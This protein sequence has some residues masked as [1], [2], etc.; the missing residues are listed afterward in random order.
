MN[1]KKPDISGAAS[2]PPMS[3]FLYNRMARP[4]ASP[5]KW[6]YRIE[7]T[8]AENWPERGPALIASNH[9]SNF[10]PVLL[11]LAYPGIIRWMAKAELWK[12]PG[13]G[14]LINRLGAF[15]VHRGEADR[16][17][18]REA[19][20]LLRQGGVVGMFPEGTR[21][22]DGRLGEPQPGVGMLALE[23]GI[24]VVPVRIRGSEGI[25]RG[26]IPRRPLV[27]ITV[28]KPVPMDIDGMS[29]GKAFQEAARRIMTAISGL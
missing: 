21:Q 19:R 12:V 2:L 14:G 26:G 4:V 22:R 27:S 18:I 25:I 5:L 24:E 7:V 15:P 10:D 29:R 8:G 17:A 3:P 13:L 1:D 28:G 16:E 20:A 6:L 9:G 11:G 23:P